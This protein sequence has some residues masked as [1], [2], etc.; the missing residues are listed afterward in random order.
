[1]STVLSRHGLSV[2]LQD[3]WEAAIFRRPP[4]CGEETHA[5]MHVGSFPLAPGRGDYG[6]AAVETMRRDDVFVALLED[7]PGSAGT[8]LYR[9]R[10]MPRSLAP[11][12]FSPATLQR[13]IPGQA[14]SQTFFAESGRAFRLYVVLGSWVESTVLITKVNTVL[15]AIGIERR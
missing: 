7:D 5:V 12:Q 8:A 3:G 9:G 2:T 6:S 13:V 11:E 4:G 10:G 14:G 1:M 15:P